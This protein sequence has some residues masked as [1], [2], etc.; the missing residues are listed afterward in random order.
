MKTRITELFSI[1][2]P[3]VLSGMSWIS[4]PEMVAAVSEAGGLGILA[5]GVYN[6]TQ[7]REAVR[8]VKELTDKPFGANA[9]LYFPGARAN[10]KVLLEEQV[11]VIN[12][13]M[14]KGD[15]IVKAAHEYGG[16]VIGTVVNEEHAKKAAAYGTNALLVTGHEAAAHGGEMTTLV[17]VPN[18]ADA[19]DVPIIAAGGIGDGRGLAAALSLGADAVAMGTRLMNTKES[20]IHDNCK[21]LAIEKGSDDTVFTTRFD[22]QP[23][24]VMKAPGADKAIRRG[25]SLGR[26]F[27]TSREVAQMMGMNHLKM[28]AGVTASGWKT[29]KMMAFMA[30]AF[31]AFRLATTEG[32]VDKG[33]LPLGQVTALVNDT[34]SVA[35]VIDRVV[36][37]ADTVIE[38]LRGL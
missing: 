13:S 33:V 37:E 32:D 21:R 18:I 35:E 9:T 4:I 1:Q 11:P 5:T 8:K 30:N 22:G 2:H 26:A 7:T 29:I 31:K 38:R 20:P 36:A 24:R 12:F 27:F 14:G 28:A 15:W 25:L 17:L 10:A 16:K 23:C 19:V 3:V 6:A 34:P